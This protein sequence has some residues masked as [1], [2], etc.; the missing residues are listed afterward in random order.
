MND[1]IIPAW[2]FVVY[3]LAV[4]F[5]G[6]G[7][8]SGRAD[9]YPPRKRA[10]REQWNEFLAEMSLDENGCPPCDQSGGSECVD[11]PMPVCKRRFLAASDDEEEKS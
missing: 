6:I 7:F 8:E 9:L 2:L 1:V 11:G 4:F 3:I 10:H 5:A